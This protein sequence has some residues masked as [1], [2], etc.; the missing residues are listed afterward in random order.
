M[1][2]IVTR[3]PTSELVDTSVEEISIG[4]EPVKGRTYRG[5]HRVPQGT[6]SPCPIKALTSA[7]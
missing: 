6:A 3:F 5:D 7:L 4:R 2:L 1:F